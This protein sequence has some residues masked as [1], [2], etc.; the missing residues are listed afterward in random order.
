ME[1]EMSVP[2]FAPFS[3]PFCFPEHLCPDLPCHRPSH[4]ENASDLFLNDLNSREKTKRR[5]ITLFQL[6]QWP[7]SQLL[8]F[9]EAD[10]VL[11]LNQVMFKIVS[12]L[13]RQDPRHGRQFS[14]RGSEWTPKLDNTHPVPVPPF[15]S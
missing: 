5:E 14:C 7:P 12:T 6:T 2:P 10:S 11:P 13:H 8:A 15:R 1:K 3:P 4:S 9:L